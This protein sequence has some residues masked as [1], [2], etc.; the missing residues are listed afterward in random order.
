MMTAPVTGTG[1]RITGRAHNLADEE[2]GGGGRRAETRDVG[3][4]PP[5]APQHLTA[6]SLR[7]EQDLAV[8]AGRHNQVL[9]EVED[10]AH[11]ARM[12]SQLPQRRT[13]GNRV[14]SAGPHLGADGKARAESVDG[15]GG[16]GAGAE[17][18]VCLEQLPVRRAPHAH[19]PRRSRHKQPG[20]R[21]VRHAY[22]TSAP[23]CSSSLLA[24][25]LLGGAVQSVET[26]DALGGVVG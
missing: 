7:V 6:L 2:C 23:A 15:K 9:I 17:A 26:T 14:L 16:D 1:L 20:P 21:H 3:P 5:D 13:A 11:G 24:A 10:R 18:R 12:P 19:Q 25:G 4:M 8:P 22:H